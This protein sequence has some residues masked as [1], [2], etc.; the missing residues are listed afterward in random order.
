MFCYAKGLT[1]LVSIAFV[2][3]FDDFDVFHD[4]DMFL[5]HRSHIV[6]IACRSMCGVFAPQIQ[7]RSPQCLSV[8]SN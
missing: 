8:H 2:I 6:N 5:V 1:R 3:G 4:F 7:I